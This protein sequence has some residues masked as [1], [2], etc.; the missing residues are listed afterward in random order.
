MPLKKGSR[1]PSGGGR[2]KGQGMSKVYLD[3]WSS[4]YQA[5]DD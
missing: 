1:A 2:R 5:I 4:A 3:F